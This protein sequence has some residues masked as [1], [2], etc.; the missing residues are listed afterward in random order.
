MELEN[1]FC[2]NLKSKTKI[3]VF[4]FCVSVFPIVVNQYRCFSAGFQTDLPTQTSR[5]VNNTFRDLSAVHLILFTIRLS[6]LMFVI[7]NCRQTSNRV[8]VA[9]AE[10]QRLKTERLWIRITSL[11]FQV[12]KVCKFVEKNKQ[13]K[14]QKGAPKILF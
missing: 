14:S 10:C 13:L 1:F 11:G 4:F 3:S 6:C 12:S 9:G 7:I 5:L 8:L 2:S